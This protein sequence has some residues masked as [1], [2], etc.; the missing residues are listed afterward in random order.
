MSANSRVQ[1]QKSRTVDR[2][3]TG[4][5]NRKRISDQFSKNPNERGT[6]QTYPKTPPGPQRDHG[7]TLGGSPRITS[8][9]AAEER[10]IINLLLREQ[11]LEKIEREKRQKEIE[12]QRQKEELLAKRARDVEFNK[13]KEQEQILDAQMETR[14]YW[15]S[16]F[17]EENEENDLAIAIQL[18]LDSKFTEESKEYYQEQPKV[19]SEPEIFELPHMRQTKVPSFRIPDEENYEQQRKRIEI[20]REK[21]ILK[22]KLE[23]LEKEEHKLSMTNLERER[24]LKLEQ[25]LAFDEALCNDMWKEEMK[26]FKEQTEMDA[27]QH[28]NL[29]QRSRMEMKDN[30][31]PEPDSSS[32]ILKL[33]F[34]MPNG[35]IF[36]RS[37]LVDTQLGEVLDFIEALGSDPATN[38]AEE[39]NVYADYPPRTFHDLDPQLSLTEANIMPNEVLSV[40][41]S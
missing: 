19:P 8:L 21:E 32:N 27:Q 39:Y 40:I 7:N 26:L 22:K 9:E 35:K 36:S 20:Q 25:D 1:T 6:H 10:K 30:L 24:Q 5:R 18:S 34:R 37:F 13:Q 29:L 2:D 17:D 41:N 14:M 15:N 11:K 4:N 31:S 16:K 12:L 28:Q 3:N 23:E 33:K 38:L